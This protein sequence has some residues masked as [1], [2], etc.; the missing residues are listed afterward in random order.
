MFI[1]F[2]MIT[3]EQS[4]KMVFFKKF[5][6]LLIYKSSHKNYLCEYN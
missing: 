3:Y 5:N 6:P 2:L 1:K 4:Q